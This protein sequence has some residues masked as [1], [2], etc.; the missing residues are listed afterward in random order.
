MW[1]WMIPFPRNHSWF[2]SNAHQQPYSY[3][4]SAHGILMEMESHKH[5]SSCRA[6]H[7]KVGPGMTFG[8]RNNLTPAD[9]FWSHFP[10]K[11]PYS[12]SRV[13]DILVGREST[14]SGVAAGLLM[15][16]VTG[17]G[18]IPWEWEYSPLPCIHRLRW[19]PTHN[20]PARYAS[21]TGFLS[22]TKRKTTTTRTATTNEIERQHHALNS[23]QT[24]CRVL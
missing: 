22:E 10:H 1:M 15:G 13:R 2:H 20:N 6:V 4:Y 14:G 24:R 12:Y 5:G 23:T 7:A 21:V 17:P 19:R 9:H 11:Q 8:N 16:M 18:M 3:Y